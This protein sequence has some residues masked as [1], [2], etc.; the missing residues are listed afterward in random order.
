MRVTLRQ[1]QIIVCLY[2]TME[3]RANATLLSPHRIYKMNPQDRT[4]PK[5]FFHKSWRSLSGHRTEDVFLSRLPS[6]GLT[7]VR[8]CASVNATPPYVISSPRK[9]SMDDQS[10]TAAILPAQNDPQEILYVVNCCHCD[11]PCQLQ[12]SLY[13]EVL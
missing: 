6:G 5:Q 11:S 3:L 13:G 7:S 2:K 10:S 8:A 9:V 4:S 1:R 12:G